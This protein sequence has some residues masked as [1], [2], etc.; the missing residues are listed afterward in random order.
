MTLDS[1]DFKGSGD[2][3]WCSTT[4]DSADFKGSGDDV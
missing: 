1:A 3:V 2:D 4:L